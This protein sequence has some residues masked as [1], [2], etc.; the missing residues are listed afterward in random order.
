ME[1]HRG[2]LQTLVLA[3]FVVGLYAQ[4]EAFWSLDYYFQGVLLSWTKHFKVRGVRDTDVV[5]SLRKALQKHKA[6]FVPAGDEP[7]EPQTVLLGDQLFV[8]GLFWKLS[9]FL[10]GQP[11]TNG[12]I[13]RR[14]V[15]PLEMKPWKGTDVQLQLRLPR[16]SL[17]VVATAHG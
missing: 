1:R 15:S 17:T 7:E 11:V 4:V 10:Q 3:A 2:L 5:S 9:D 12:C 8:C 6:S 13:S 16:I 14:S